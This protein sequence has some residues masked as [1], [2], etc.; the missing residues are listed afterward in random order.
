MK[1]F[2]IVGVDGN[3]F[4]IMGYVLNAMKVAY[5]SAAL[6]DED[7]M[8]SNEGKE[9]F[10]ANAQTAY[11]KRAMSG[12]YSNLLCVSQEMIEKVNEFMKLEPAYEEDDEYEDFY[13]D[14]ENYEDDYE[15]D[16]CADEYCGDDYSEGL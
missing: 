3:A 10:G 14:E 16:Y 12:D 4:S 1:A 9:Q 7:G 6:P 15:D 13:D 5:R 11:Q 2:N 8:A